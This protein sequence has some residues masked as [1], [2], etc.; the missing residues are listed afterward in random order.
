[1]L[2][3]RT[4][5]QGFV[6]VLQVPQ[7]G[8]TLEIGFKAAQRLKTTRRLIFKTA[9]MRG[10]QSVQCEFRALPFSERSSL[11]QEG[12][13][14]RSKPESAVSRTP[15]AVMRYFTTVPLFNQ[16]QTTV[17]VCSTSRSHLNPIP[18][19]SEI[20]KAKLTPEIWDAAGTWSGV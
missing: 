16:P 1:M 8:I 10:E 19:A 5:K 9:N 13:L 11:V 3:T 12:K 4:V 20:T 2:R 14:I 6:R 7:V 15:S 17:G 18:F